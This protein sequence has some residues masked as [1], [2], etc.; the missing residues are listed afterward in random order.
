MTAS[1]FSIPALLE[2]NAALY[3]ERP[4]ISGE[5][6]GGWSHAGLWD[7]AKTSVSQLNAMGIGRGDCV[8]I[9]MPQGP[10]MAMAF[11]AIACGAITAP[12]NPAYVEREFLF[13]LEDLEARALVCLRGDASPARLA[14]QA[15][16]IPV[17]EI[18]ARESGK[19]DFVGPAGKA[20]SAPGIS[21]AENV[22]LILHTSG[23]TSRPKMV[24][25]THGNL[26][27]SAHQISRTLE[28]AHN[29]ICLNV[30]P[31]FHIHGLGASILASLYAGGSTLCMRAFDTSQ[32]L[33]WLEA[34]KPSWYSAVPTMHQAIL[35]HLKAQGL[36]FV[37]T[38]LRFIRS[39]SAALPPSVMSSL[40]QILHVPMIEAYG[41][42]ETSPSI[43]SNPLPPLKR[44]PGCVGLP[45][46]PEIAILDEAGNFLSPGSTGEIAIRGANVTA[47]YRN[48]PE[49]NAQAF[50]EGWLRTGDQG[51]FDPDGYLYIRGRLKEVINRGGEKLSPHELEDVLLSHPMVGEAVAFAVPHPSLGEDAA[52]AVVLHEGVVCTEVD[53]KNFLRNRL[54]SFKVLSRIVIVRD[55]PKGPTGK[56]Q[57]LGLA[58]RLAGYLA[59]VYE[60]PQ[61]PMEKQIEDMFAEMLGCVPGGRH[62]DFFRLGGD[63]LRATQVIIRL[64]QSLGLDLP[65][66][67]LF[68]LSTPAKL[69]PEL[70]RLK[71]ETELDE[72]VSAM[73]GL[74]H[75][76]REN[77]LR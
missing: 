1:E 55:I 65:P 42:T 53:L 11:L 70:E 54:S 4:A 13:H 52:A 8:A 77:L 71:A 10:E 51:F 26:L 66:T 29:D 17:V 16:G 48:N 39:A 21:N 62:G 72:L 19:V 24:P 47:G 63:S 59:T 61:C 34:G 14:A 45:A 27:F 5:D 64:S 31:L 7:Q 57:R 20:T 3:G 50:H 2:K 67:L 56:I 74:S 9:V 12:L 75:T 60:E 41:M 23:T 6:G 28:L 37:K 69:A 40:E 35:T 30:L 32:F 38:H 15:L 58:G 22:A 36:A 43:A 44:K 49:A 68:R 46:G 73:S 18:A 33:G 25:L 76:E